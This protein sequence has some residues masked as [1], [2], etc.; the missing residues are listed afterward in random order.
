MTMTKAFGAGAR[1]PVPR[2]ARVLLGRADAL[3]TESIGGSDADRF[4]GGYAAALKGAAAL[5]A[6]VPG[7]IGARPRSRSAWVLMA[8]AVPDLAIWAEFFASYSATRAAVEAG[9]SSAVADLDTDDFHRQVGRFLNAVDDRLGGQM[10][11][12]SELLV[13]TPLS[14]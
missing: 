1:S 9:A 6:S 8:K 14:A 3:L 4:L 10:R 2:Q 5:L 12:E 13:S 11:V 7:S